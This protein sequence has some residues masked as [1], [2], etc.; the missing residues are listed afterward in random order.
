MRELTEFLQTGYW[1]NSTMPLQT[2]AG[3]SAPSKRRLCL[4]APAAPYRRWARDRTLNAAAL[5]LVAI[6]TG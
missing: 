1:G 5:R 6:Q 3:G 4:V 2:L